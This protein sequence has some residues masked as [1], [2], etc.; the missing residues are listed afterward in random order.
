MS[1]QVLQITCLAPW[2]D[3]FELF[4]QRQFPGLKYVVKYD[5]YLDIFLVSIYELNKLLLRSGHRI[6]NGIFGS[7][8]ILDLS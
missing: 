4:A 3:A 7:G 6:Q 2:K 1:L 5:V 8:P